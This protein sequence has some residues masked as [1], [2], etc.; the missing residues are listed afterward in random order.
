MGSGFHNFHVPFGHSRVNGNP[1]LSTFWIPA[2]AGMTNMFLDSY[3]AYESYDPSDHSE[4]NEVFFVLE[5]SGGIH[6]SRNN[7]L[8]LHKLPLLCLL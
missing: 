4:I 7:I 8:F 1:G 5:I 6:S 2:Y 3:G